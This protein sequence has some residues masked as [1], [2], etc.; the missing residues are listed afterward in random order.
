MRVSGLLTV[1][2]VLRVDWVNGFESDTGWIS[3][4]MGVGMV[5]DG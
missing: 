3:G 4:V 5:L 1:G 2:L